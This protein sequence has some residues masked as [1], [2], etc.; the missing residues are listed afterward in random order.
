M[1]KTL[2]FGGIFLVLTACVMKTKSSKEPAKLALSPGEQKAFTLEENGLDYYLYLPENYNKADALPFML[3]L[4]GAGERGDSIEQLLQWGPPKKVANGESM[5]FIIASPQCPTN[6]YW[7]QDDQLDR[8]VALMDHVEANYKVDPKRVYVTGLSMGG[9]GTWYLS[10]RYND[11]IAAAAPIC[12]GGELDSAA[13]IAEVP[14]WAFHG[15]KDP[16]VPLVRSSEMV[17]AVNAA[18]GNAKLTI[19]PDEEHLSWRPAYANDSLYTWLLSHSL[20]R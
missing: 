12:G 4:H 8:L 9:Y 16:V 11:R 14:I 13:A 5:P 7:P 18:G 20:D 1:K 17:D 15:A 3:F 2:L 10:A 19:Y 6:K